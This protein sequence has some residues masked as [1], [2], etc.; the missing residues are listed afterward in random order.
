MSAEPRQWSDEDVAAI[1]RLRAD[2][3]TWAEV[4]EVLGCSRYTLTLFARRIGLTAE[5][6]PLPSLPQFVRNDDYLLDK[7]R[8]PLP[9]GHDESWLPILK[10]TPLLTGMPYPI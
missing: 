6:I 3:K 9:P 1:K 7:H 2:K 4:G 5:L 10:N 8:P